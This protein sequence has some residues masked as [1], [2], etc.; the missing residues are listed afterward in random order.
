[1]W[2][3]AN[4]A[5]WEWD[6]WPFPNRI[7]REIYGRIDFDAETFLERY[8]E[9]NQEVQDYFRGRPRDL[10]VK[11]IGSG[12]DGLCEFLDVPVPDVPYPHSNR[13]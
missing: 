7:H 3:T 1:L 8:R 10:L 9:H 12:W 13:S 11:G 5:R 6:V 2:S 4:P